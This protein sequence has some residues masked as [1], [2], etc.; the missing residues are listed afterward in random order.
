MKIKA[1]PVVSLVA[2][3]V[4]IAVVIWLMAFSAGRKPVS[5]VSAQPTA[6]NS[7]GSA[8][9]GVSLRSAPIG[10]DEWA[11]AM[12]QLRC[13]GVPGAIIAK[14]V[15]EG[16]AQ[17]WTLLETELER[18]YLNGEIDA[19]QLARKHDERA[20]E[21][22]RELRAALGDGFVEWDREHTVGT[23]YLGGHQPT[24]EQKEL[25]YALQKDWLR[26]L[27]ELEVANRNGSLSDA[28]L[29]DERAKGEADFKTKLAG[30]IGTER[31]DGVASV[32]DPA[33]RVRQEFSSMQLTDTQ[34]SRLAEVQT[35]WEKARGEMAAF[36][37]QTRT[38]DAAYEGDLK[39]LDRARDD[40][41]RRILGE[42]SFDAWQKAGDDRYRLLRNN[43][44]AWGLDSKQIDHVYATVRAY[45][46][47]VATLEHQSQVREQMGE[48]V[49]WRT[50]ED[51][52]AD[53]TRQTAADLRAF[54]GEE[55]FIAMARQQIFGLRQSARPPHASAK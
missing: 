27:R 51:N 8:S 29:E 30:I 38:M 54:L 31:V 1:W 12:T 24:D 37:A 55:R 14:V 35:Q 45:D 53:Y 32:E 26:R 44:Q 40:D 13:A 5:S 22:E 33:Q 28:G 20:Q 42:E 16:I 47:A 7:L 41:Y 11:L 10:S 17:K 2:N 50:L 23:M 39:A 49:D 18:R 21:E 34:L 48:P 3:A 46:L 9:R 19:K 25:L 6:S 15:V 43:A 52:L 36:L 4:L